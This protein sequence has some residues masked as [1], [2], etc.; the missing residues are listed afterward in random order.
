MFELYRE[1][2][3]L[4]SHTHPHIPTLPYPLRR[5]IPRDGQTLGGATSEVD[6]VVAG[7]GEG[8]ENGVVQ[9]LAVS[10]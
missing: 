5:P 6:V 4:I 8:V 1:R 7:F 2:R 3:R 10:V 9:M